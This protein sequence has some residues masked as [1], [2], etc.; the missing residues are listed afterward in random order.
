MDQIIPGIK[1]HIADQP[2]L[3]TW[4]TKFYLHNTRIASRFQSELFF[5]IDQ[6]W[7]TAQDRNITLWADL[8]FLD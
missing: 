2:E 6:S 8:K 3:E 4:Y 1:Y 5:K 7:M